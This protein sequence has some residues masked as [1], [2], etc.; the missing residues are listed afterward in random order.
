M[1]MSRYSERKAKLVAKYNTDIPEI[2]EDQIE[3]IREHYNKKA[4]RAG[5]DWTM[6]AYA[7]NDH[8]LMLRYVVSHKYDCKELQVE[9]RARIVFDFGER[10]TYMF[11]RWRTDDKWKNTKC[12]YFRYGSHWNHWNRQYFTCRDTKKYA[13]GFMSELK[14]INALNYL[15][16]DRYLDINKWW[17]TDAVH[18]L[19]VRGD[20]YEKLTKVGLAEVAEKDFLSYSSREIKFNRNESSL[21]KMLGID[22]RYFK[23]FKRTKSL[24]ALKMLQNYPGFT[25][26]EIK[27]A[28]VVDWD[29][30]I[31]IRLR[32]TGIAME[33][34]LNYVEKHSDK[35]FATEWLNHFYMLKELDYPLDKSYLFPADFVA[36]HT[37]LIAEKNERERIKREKADMIRNEK[38]RLLSEAMRS[39]REFREFF[40]GCDG[41]MIRVPESVEDLYKEGKMLHNCLST[42]GERVAN[43]TS[44][45]FFI[46]RVDEPNAPYVAM[47]YSNGRI[48]QC[49]FDY[50]K[51][52]HDEKI[53]NFTNRLAAKLAAAA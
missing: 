7:I 20:L 43:G 23:V 48:I 19:I 36:E 11:E 18:T 51:D 25:D 21:L 14:K 30:N 28:E 52:V 38:I 42:Y 40:D 16:I 41:L 32:N 22:R 15:D 35:A 53:I 1:I 6:T 4:N 31:I 37:R 24:E 34:I 17:L 2:P 3:W 10:K 27:Y 44:I 47:E 9:E 45:I 5:V 29:G 8:T 12:C 46:R 33:R 39:N 49:R 13:P 50:N 26:R